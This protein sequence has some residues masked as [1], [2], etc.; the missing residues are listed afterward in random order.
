MV[1]LKA[2][3]ISVLSS[4]F[5]SEAQRT[6]DSHDNECDTTDTKGLGERATIPVA[7]AIADAFSNAAGIR[8]TASITVPQ[9]IGFVAERRKRGRVKL[10]K[11]S[12]KRV[13]SIKEAVE[14][15]SRPGARNVVGG[16]DLLACLRDEVFTAAT[17]VSVS[18]RKGLKGMSGRPGG[19]LRVRALTTLSEI[20]DHWQVLA[21]YPVLAQAA[22]SAASPQLRNQGTIGR[23]LCQRPRC[24]YF[25][26]DFHCLR[27]GGESCFAVLGENQFH[28]VFGGQL[29]FIVHPSDT[30]Q[31]L[32]AL[33]A[34]I[35]IV[36]PKGARTVPLASFFALPKD[37]ALKENVLVPAN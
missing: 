17:V 2:R 20:A 37:N 36:G 16:T 15:A 30:A 33:D 4:L 14:A 29:C 31:A 3:Q 28:C 9:V 10:G 26:G 12:Y 19:G 11:F 18:G 1:A 35:T 27:K 32:V 25:R 13:G 24:W 8:I 5:K 21:S 34:R 23:K 22:A 7:A 6:D